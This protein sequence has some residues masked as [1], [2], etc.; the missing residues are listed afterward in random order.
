M[1]FIDLIKAL[2]DKVSRLKDTIQTEEA[3]KNAPLCVELAQ[4]STHLPDKQSLIGSA[5]TSVPTR[6]QL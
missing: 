5:V 1:D 2:G 3:T 4:R 6:V